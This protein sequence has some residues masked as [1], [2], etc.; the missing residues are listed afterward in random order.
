MLIGRGFPQRHHFLNLSVTGIEA[1]PNQTGRPFA[2]YPHLWITLWITE[3]TSE[4]G[5]AMFDR[6]FPAKFNRLH[7][8]ASCG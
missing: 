7:E 2:A 5:F 6:N 4:E 8:E 3:P 1:G